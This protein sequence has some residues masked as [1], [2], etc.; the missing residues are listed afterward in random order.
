MHVQQDLK[1]V[2]AARLVSIAA[3]RA[4]MAVLAVAYSAR[5]GA[6]NKLDIAR[7]AERVTSAFGL[8]HDLSRE[9]LGFVTR[10]PELRR[11]VPDLAE[12]G[13]KLIRAVERTT[14]PDAD[15]RADIHG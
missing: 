2:T 6:V 9:M 8:D 7:A 10:L 1:S 15:G 12:A 13:D 4:R 3:I 14:W 11:H 5:M